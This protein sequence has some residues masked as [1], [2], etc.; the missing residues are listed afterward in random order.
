MNYGTD[1]KS[2]QLGMPF[3]TAQGRLLKR[4]LFSMAQKLQLDICFQCKEKIEIVEDFSIEHKKP[5][6][7]VS[8]DLYWDLDNIAFSHKSCNYGAARKDI[9]RMI[10]Q[11]KKVRKDHCINAPEGKAW[12]YGHNS[13]LNKNLFNSNKWAP[14]GVQR[15]C[16][17]CRSSGIGR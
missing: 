10:E 12:C 9:P 2:Q 13:Y 14:L 15:Y 3:G 1:K 7:D 16:K 4:L 17:E 5:W 6:L 8:T 11:L